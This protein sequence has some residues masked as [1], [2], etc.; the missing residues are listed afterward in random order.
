[1]R[2]R[3]REAARQTRMSAPTIRMSGSNTLRADPVLVRQIQE[4]M[5]ARRSRPLR[6]EN[7]RPAE[8]PIGSADNPWPGYDGRLP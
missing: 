1:M 7:N 4:Q 8:A 2:A 6:V 3:A 5:T